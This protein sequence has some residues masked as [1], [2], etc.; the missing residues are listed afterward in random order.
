MEQP[1]KNFIGQ[2]FC[3]HKWENINDLHLYYSVE[4]KNANLPNKSYKRWECKNCG[5][6]IRRRII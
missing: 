1:P 4:D 5:K 6:S 3:K 2:L